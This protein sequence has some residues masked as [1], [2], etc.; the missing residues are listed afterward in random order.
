MNT[1]PFSREVH[2]KRSFEYMGRLLDRGWNILLFPEG[3]LT[4]T[5]QIDHFKPGIGLLVQAMQVPVV[6]IRLD[7]LYSIANYQHWIPRRLGR[8]Q[9]TFGRP[10]CVEELADPGKLAGVFEEAIRHLA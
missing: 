5:G 9:V 8:V 4:T 2:V 1:F 3:K 7:G 6:P 10:V